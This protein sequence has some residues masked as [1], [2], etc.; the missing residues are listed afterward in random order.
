M[1]SIERFKKQKKA[2]AKIEC[3]K[4]LALASDPTLVGN[5]LASEV[6]SNVIHA[7]AE[8]LNAVYDF[9]PDLNVTDQE[10]SDLLLF[11]GKDFND[12]RFNQLVEACKKDVISAIVTP[13]GIGRYIAKLDKIGG[14]V[15]TINN[16]G[17]QIY[18][19]EVDG[20]NR[21]EYTHSKNSNGQAFAGQGKKSVGSEFTKN[22]LDESQTLSDAYTGKR[23]S[24]SNTSPDH[25]VSNSEFHKDGGFMLS[26]VR[27]A[28]F[29]TDTGNLASTRRDI[30]QSMSDNDN[31]EWVEKSR[32]VEKKPMQNIMRLIQIY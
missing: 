4:G 19:R 14:N 11:M 5:Y 18:A 9:Q 17:Q 30:N 13:F 2:L 22:Q 6:D 31:L 26:S 25:I 1:N 29:A 21:T 3:R 28:D 16:A 27:K 10:V 32:M 23:E 7:A 20:Y 12:Q 15:T 24:G 8:R